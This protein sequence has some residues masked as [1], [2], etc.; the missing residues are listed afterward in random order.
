LPLV[1]NGGY[2]LRQPTSTGLGI[3]IRERDEIMN[4]KCFGNDCH[5]VVV[6]L[7]VL[8]G[9]ASHAFPPDA[10]G[11]VLQG[12]GI[13][14]SSLSLTG[15]GGPVIQSRPVKAPAEQAD[16]FTELFDATTN[17][18]GFQT[19]TFTPD[20]S[21]SFYR[22]CREAAADFPTDPA[23]GTAV[24]MNDDMGVR[25]MLTG[26]HGVSLYG[27]RTNVFFIGS[28]GYLTLD[29]GDSGFNE[30]FAA[31]F[32]RPRVSALF[33]DLYP[34][35]GQVTWKQMSN[36][37]AVTYLNVPEFGCANT[38]NF[39]VEW[40]EDGRI[41]L[42]Y[43]KIDAIDGLAG[44]SDGAGVP[45]GFAESDFTAYRLCTPPLCVV[46]PAGATEG[47]GVLPGAG[48]VWL[49]EAPAADLPVAL[50]SGDTREVTVPTGVIIPAGQTNALF[51]LNILNDTELDG[52]Q[53]ALISAMAPGY[54]AASASIAIA[55]N[56]T[57]VLHVAL[58][59]AAT[60]GQGTVTG[61][62]CVAGGVPAADVRVNLFSSDTGEIQVPAIVTIASGQTS[63]G[64]AGAVLDD[65]RIDG[66]QPVTVT[67][68]VQNWMDGSANLTVGDN[69][70]TNLTVTLPDSAR[71][72]AG[73]LTNAG[74]VSLSGTV[75]TD[76]MVALASDDT[77]ELLVPATV[78]IRA[79]QATAAFDL[80]VMDDPDLDGAQ[81]ARVT[82][83]ASGFIDG[84]QAMTIYDDESPPAPSNPS[85]AHLASGTAQTNGL[86]WQSGAATG[87]I[88]T[89]DV[90]F[91]TNP[92]PGAGEW[93]GSTTNTGWALPRLAPQTTY[94]WQIVAR[95]GGT[96]AGPVW[97]F[98][99][100][101]VDHF[102]LS[103]VS[104]PRYVG[105]PFGLTVTA[106]DAFDAA[107]SNFTG[108]VAL[109]G[110][111]GSNAA[112]LFG[113]D[114]EDGE[115]SGW[116]IDS[117]S[118]VRA[119]TNQTA[120]G[121]NYSLTLIGGNTNHGDGLSCSFSNL[122][123]ARITFQVR[124]GATNR[125]GGYFVV[126]TNITADNNIMAWFYM[127]ENGTMGIQ[128]NFGAWHGVPYAANQWYKISLLLDWVNRRLDYCVNDS[129]AYTNILFRNRG[130]SSLTRVYLYNFH[131]TQAWWDEIRFNDAGLPIPVDIT[132]T[133]SRSFVHGVWSGSVSVRQAA[134]NVVLTADDGGGHSGRSSAFD[135]RLMATIGPLVVG[136]IPASATTVGN[137]I[138]FGANAGFDFTGFIY[139]D[140]PAFAVF[141]GDKV[142]FDLG[143]TNDVEV[144]RNIY[145][146]PA[147]VN[148]VAG[149]D[150]QDVQAL[151]WTKIVSDLQVPANPRG[152][153]VAG[154]YE[155]AYTLEN[156]FA[157]AGG[158][159]IIG[160]GGAPP[161][162]YA[163]GTGDQVLVGTTAGDI[164][165]HFHRR[166]Y[167]HAD[168]DA[169]VLDDENSDGSYLGGFI[170]ESAPSLPAFLP[171]QLNAGRAWLRFATVSGQL[172]F[173]EYKD[174][175]TDPDWAPLR[176]V[177]GDGTV[178]TI[179]D[180]NAAGPQRF[181]RLRLP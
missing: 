24:P 5:A 68:R 71:E 132:Q 116:N 8:P 119:V 100:R 28:N 162:N 54:R 29:A 151:G 165:G 148:P 95:R 147:S 55:D 175:L 84:S 114:F 126:G 80:T 81:I 177:S 138:P 58:P 15:N 115:C 32:D 181:Y 52:T 65:S 31:H 104:S 117:G 107:V 19:F 9:L 123:P 72:G 63:A 90:Y 134:T 74:M 13:H 106:R 166:F 141:P 131:H 127:A 47:D 172:Y 137:C 153:L 51:D 94:Y 18:L 25:V 60:E 154:D 163:D 57:A 169:G 161:G 156:P 77:S 61:A 110:S 11:A 34:G 22:V 125:A 160:F 88:I 146:A 70:N 64:F 7:C 59:A 157:F 145:I 56:E 73:T 143:R 92:M 144:R 76:M 62:V 69:E 130:I 2:G 66:A 40:F 103:P 3:Q 152:N 98:T 6:A 86:G 129:P 159:L 179:T 82:A 33:D 118:Y 108:M 97:Q 49:A 180:T 36:R 38:N 67:A 26:D 91:G 10:R 23:G 111:S 121:G 174:A 21:A 101:G 30:T 173:V 120:G 17:D 85:P 171:P 4:G 78:T 1:S 99:T 155:L 149:G 83:E 87:E 89:N 133:N 158:G 93:Q 42:T 167:L 96:T 136:I 35:T 79:G 46:V 176:I 124:A 142:R 150:P 170:I 20:G 14:P 48:Q 45:G 12:A 16:R 140:V 102:D 139:R 164:S 168:Q 37:V 75:A 178:I 53:T 43:L 39:Q 128:D 50:A 41:Q 122:S 112:V 27:R 135:V 113:E 109:R 105:M 44:L